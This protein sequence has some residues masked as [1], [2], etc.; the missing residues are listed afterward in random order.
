[1]NILYS[2]LEGQD[3]PSRDFESLPFSLNSERVP[4]NLPYVQFIA[5]VLFQVSLWSYG[6]SVSLRL[7]MRKDPPVHGLS[8][9]LGIKAETRRISLSR[10]FLPVLCWM[11]WSVYSP[12]EAGRG[13][14]RGNHVVTMRQV[15]S[16]IFGRLKILCKV[17]YNFCT[18]IS[19]CYPVFFSHYFGLHYPKSV[20]A[21]YWLTTIPTFPVPSVSFGH[22]LPLLHTPCPL[23]SEIL[24][25]IVPTGFLGQSHKWV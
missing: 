22:L 7:H 25:H 23:S 4:G 16:V 11:R 2:C 8:A 20:A 21:A 9:K 10:V 6:V 17:L 14:R 19:V 15:Y 12:W 24:T 13:Q 3:W 1:M 5:A 18:N